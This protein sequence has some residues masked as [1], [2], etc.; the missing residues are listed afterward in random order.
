[1]RRPPTAIHSSGEWEHRR[2]RQRRKGTEMRRV[3]VALLILSSLVPGAVAVPAA[4]QVRFKRGTLTLV[5]NARSAVL[6]E[7]CVNSNAGLWYADQDEFIE[8]LKLLFRD[9]RLREALGRNGRDYVR[10]N[11]RWDIV[12]ARYE[13]IFAR[14]RHGR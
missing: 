6:V 5:Q 13:R 7:H 2:G 8:C 3:V 4:A 14:V 1:M 12:L 10:R 9:S 11:Y